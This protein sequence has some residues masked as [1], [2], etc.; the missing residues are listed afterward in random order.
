VL[1][2]P[3]R[4]RVRECPVSVG[5]Q[6]GTG[7]ALMRLEPLADEGP[8]DEA[9]EVEI[10]LPPEPAGVPAAERA[11]RGL[12]H[13][14]GLLLGFDADPHGHQRVLSDYLAARDE[15][16]GGQV[17]EGELDLLTVFADLCEL[18]R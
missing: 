9:G 12:E 16:G 1:R 15:L 6:V 11:A 3:F 13:L 18:S 5:T 14:R 17:L 8:R 2:A 10:D 4:A 7:A